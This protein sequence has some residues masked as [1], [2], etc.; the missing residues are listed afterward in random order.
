VEAYNALGVIYGQA[1]E[2]D[3]AIEEFKSAIKY[4]SDYAEAHSNLSVAYKNKGK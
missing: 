1:G 2:T 4:K 3:K